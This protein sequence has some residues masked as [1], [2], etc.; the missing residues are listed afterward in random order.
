[1][2]ESCARWSLSA[3]ASTWL[4]AAP[5]AT[6]AEP[7]PHASIV[8]TVS[9]MPCGPVVA[10]CCAE[11][12]IL[13]RSAANGRMSSPAP[14]WPQALAAS[15]A[16]EIGHSAAA[17]AALSSAAVATAAVATAAAA[18]N[19][20]AP[21][22]WRTSSRSRPSVWSPLRPPYIAS[23]GTGD[24]GDNDRGNVSVLSEML[25]CST[26][27]PARAGWGWLHLPR[28]VRLFSSVPCAGAT[29]LPVLLLPAWPVPTWPLP[30]GLLPTWPLPA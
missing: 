20:A 7:S 19:A 12:S 18:S 9:A 2:P 29:G 26:V 6:S 28:R 17:E 22:A 21:T 10:S 13:G 14:L 23:S 3:L 25:K 30:I 11:S 8:A 16:S 4:V 5:S 24:S 1:M 27:A 15:P